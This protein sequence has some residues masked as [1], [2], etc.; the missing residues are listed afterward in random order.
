MVLKGS[1]HHQWVGCS[2]LVHQKQRYSLFLLSF[3][4]YKRLDTSLKFT[5]HDH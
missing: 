1:L 4:D 3:G 5:F 2:K